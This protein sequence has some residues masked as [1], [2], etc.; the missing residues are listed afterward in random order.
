MHQ[1]RPQTDRPGRDGDGVRLSFR[2][3][4]DRDGRCGDRRRRRAFDRARSVL[5]GAI[6]GEFH[7]AHRLPHDL[8]R[9]ACSVATIDDCTKWWGEDRH[10]VIYYVK[11]DRSEVYFVTSQP[12]PEFRHRI[13]V[14][15]GR[16]EGP[17]R[18]VRGL[19]SA[20]REGAGRLPGRAQMGDRRS[21]FAR[22]LG[23]RQRDAARRCLPS[24]D[25]LHGAGRRDGDRGCRRAVALPRQASSATASPT[26]FARFE[27][28]RKERTARVQQTSRANTWLK[29][30]TDTD[31]VYAYNAWTH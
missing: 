16:R 17:A 4:R 2:Q 14:G 9:R 27:A 10:I 3:R 1:A 24:D 31:W 28:T 6:A 26:R 30:K 15:E 18:G 25:A 13:L 5:F 7:R 21:R 11:P 29:E 23:G 22:A 20:G 12:E 19:P 8:S